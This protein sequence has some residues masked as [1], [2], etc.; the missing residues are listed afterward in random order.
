MFAINTKVVVFRLEYAGGF[1]ED[2]RILPEWYRDF[3]FLGASSLEALS[4]AILRILGWDP[5]HLYE[6]T[7]EDRTYADLGYDDSLFV[8]IEGI[9]AS[10]RAPLYALPLSQGQEIHYTFDFGDW[11]RFVLTIL[12]VKPAPWDGAGYPR[13][14]SWEG[15]N[16][17]QHPGSLDKAREKRYRSAAPSITGSHNPFAEETRNVRGERGD[18]YASVCGTPST[19]WAIPFVT[20]TDK[21]ELQVWRDSND[22]RLWQRAVTIL[23]NRTMSVEAIASKVERPPRSV[24]N[25]MRQYSWHGLEGIV[26]RRHGKRPSSQRNVQRSEIRQKRILEILHDRPSSFGINRSNW[27]LES[28]A[29]AYEARHGERLGKS[30]VGR[31]VSKSGYRFRKARKVLTSPDPDYREKVNLLLNTLHNLRDD[32]LLFFVDELGPLRVRK[33][34][35]RTYTKEQAQEVPQV[36]PHRGSITL[37]GALSATANQVS[38]LFSDA[39]D[40]FSMIDLIEILF[41]QHNNMSR[42]YVTWDGASW[43]RSQDL[44]DWLDAFNRDTEQRQDGPTIFLLPLPVSA[45]FL[46]VIEAVFSGMKR[47]VIHHSDYRSTREMKSAISAHFKDRNDFFKQNPQRAGKKIW[48]IDFFEDYDNLPSGNYREW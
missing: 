9:S 31:L 5:C 13:L 12:S 38:W 16:I 32:E 14:L 36:Q 33:Y 40:T 8:D 29:R 17:V 21:Q 42:L 41:N 30:T 2:F 37:A 24:Q 25:W 34:G 45:Q 27:N 7:I 28:L 26:D 3:E 20:V 22:K 6:F 1:G 11:H 10:C 23:E 48:D 35:G 47:A 4:E 43:H 18:N 39:K 15:E 44:F 19:K 46:D